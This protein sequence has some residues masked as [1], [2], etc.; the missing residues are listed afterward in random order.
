MS[1][2]LVVWLAAIGPQSEWM[3]PINVDWST[4]GMDGPDKRRLLQQLGKS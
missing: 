2:T 4:V 1:H 3:G